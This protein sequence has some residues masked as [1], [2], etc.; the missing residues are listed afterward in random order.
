M[1]FERFEDPLET[2]FGAFFLCETGD[3]EHCFAAMMEDGEEL[4]CKR[5]GFD[6]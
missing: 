2:G 3:A 6:A 4:H 5:D 1:A